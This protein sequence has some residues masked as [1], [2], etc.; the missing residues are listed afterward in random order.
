[1]EAGRERVRERRYGVIETA[2]GALV[3]VHLRPWPKLFSLREL[4]PV[5][6]RYHA[7]GAK[8]RCFLY[9][10]QPLFQPT[11]L[12]LRYVVSTSG[13]SY[14]TF[15]AALRVLDAIAELKRIDAIVCDAA[16]ARISDRLLARLGWEP[17]K[18][19]RWHR[20]YI[21][22]FYG[23]YSAKTAPARPDRPGASDAGKAANSHAGVSGLVAGPRNC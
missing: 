19:Q 8:D 7:S 18:P 9:Y 17:H 2:G 3:A 22:R 16:N 13:T 4:W 14:R 23:D 20:N 21:R 11:F 12:A 1:L 6:P 5:V 15:R 10:N